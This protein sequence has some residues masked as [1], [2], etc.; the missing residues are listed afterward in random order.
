MTTNENGKLPEHIAFIMDGNGRWAAK[1][2]KPRTE[3]HRKGAENLERI[4]DEVKKL[5]IKYITVY[6]FSTENWDRPKSEV[7]YLMKLLRKFLIKNK[8]DA[9]KKDVRIRVIGDLT[10]LDL[11]LQNK[12]RDIETVTENNKSLNLQLAINYGSRD[13]MIRGLKEIVTDF[14][15]KKFTL[16]DIDE[17]LFDKYLDTKNIPN[18]DFMIRTS[19]EKRLSNF[20][21]WQLAYSELY[22]TDTLWPDFTV[23]ELNQALEQYKLRNRR[24][25]AVYEEE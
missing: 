20:L 16:E 14:S 6:A 12:V 15:E 9:M 7:E 2:G 21:L 17:G 18:P 24:F 5:G 19:G 22:F 13:E 1:L 10:K 11:D 4:C 25:G 3:G 8:K 23:K